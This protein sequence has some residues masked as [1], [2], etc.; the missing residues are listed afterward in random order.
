MVMVVGCATRGAAA[1]G[2]ERHFSLQCA[3][4]LRVTTVPALR[5]QRGHLA[6]LL[7]FLKVAARSCSASNLSNRCSPRLRLLSSAARVVRSPGVRGCN[8]DLDRSSLQAKKA[9]FPS[10]GAHRSAG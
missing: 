7:M 6:L 5:R 8:L 9:T 1:S 2:G 10:Q 4:M 3:T